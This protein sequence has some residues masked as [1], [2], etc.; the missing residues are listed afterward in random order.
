MRSVSSASAA[1]G[2]SLVPAV[3]TSTG[4][5]GR[6]TISRLEY[7]AVRDSSS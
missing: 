3:I 4:S 5:P 2:K 6:V 1:T 7:E